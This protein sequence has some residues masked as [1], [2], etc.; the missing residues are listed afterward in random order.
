MG[1]LQYLMIHCTA[2]PEGRD[3]SAQSVK[4]MHMDKPP[5]GHGWDRV[6]YASLLLL[7]GTEHRFTTFDEDQIVSNHEL[8]YGAGEMNAV[9]CHICYVGGMDKP[10][11]NAKDTRTDAQ[12]KGLEKFVKDFLQV[13]PQVKVCGHY[14]FCRKACPSFDVQKWCEEIGIPE[15]NIYRK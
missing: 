3:V 6:G 7:D 15:T 8:T 14:D 2:T 11:K 5:K 10:Y 9:S 12:K 1:R 4:S 13:H